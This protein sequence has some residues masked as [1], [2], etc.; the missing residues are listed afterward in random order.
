MTDDDLSRL[1]RRHATVLQIETA[2]GIAP[3]IVGAIVAELVLGWPTG[4]V[5]GPIA[6]VALALILSLPMRRYRRKGYA[7]TGDRL[8][9][10]QGWIRHSDT[11]VPF[12][13]VQHIDVK[14]GLI[15]RWFGLATLVVHTAGMHNAS[16]AVPGLSRQTAV[17]IREAISARIRRETM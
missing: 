4:I 2:I 3:L 13:R 16:V 1:D 15:E 14:Q 5:I 9:Y 11:V 8:R 10:V 12:G 7:T 17:D 6:V